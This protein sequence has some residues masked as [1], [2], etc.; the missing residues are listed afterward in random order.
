VDGAGWPC[1]CT[2]SSA[3]WAS[4]STSWLR[5]WGRGPRPPCMSGWCRCS[6]SGWASCM[7]RAASACRTGGARGAV[8]ARRQLA[9]CVRVGL[10]RHLR[11]GAS[12]GAG[13]EASTVQCCCAG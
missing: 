12:T 4:P 7:G 11:A 9:G 3:S 5:G 2:G 10:E 8:G 6:R 1:R 13:G